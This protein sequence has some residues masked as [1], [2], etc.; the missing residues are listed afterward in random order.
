MHRWATV[1]ADCIR[2]LGI[3]AGASLGTEL[4]LRVSLISVPSSY[5]CSQNNVFSDGERMLR[6]KNTV[7][8]VLII[9]KTACMEVTTDILYQGCECT[10]QV[11]C[12]VLHTEIQSQLDP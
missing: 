7:V 9:I 5:C 10:T 12:A 6:K 8:F 2:R 3:T 11:L 4:T 1:R